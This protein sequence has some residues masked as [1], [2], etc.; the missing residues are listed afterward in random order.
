MR[1]LSFE[2]DRGRLRGTFLYLKFLS[3]F[4]TRLVELER[5][6]IRREVD[7]TPR[8][9]PRYDRAEQRNVVRLNVEQLSR[10]SI[11]RFTRRIDDGEIERGIG[12]SEKLHHVG[13]NEMV[14][15]AGESIEAQIPSR[16]F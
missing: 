16:P 15:R 9:H 12:T 8:A 3:F 14:M 4:K 5:A 13:S 11:G 10:R 1:G 6:V 7:F 2:V